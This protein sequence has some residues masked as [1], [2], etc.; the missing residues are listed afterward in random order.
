MEDDPQGEVVVSGEAFDVI[1]FAVA[2]VMLF[3]SSMVGCAVNRVLIT[4]LAML[5]HSL[6]DLLR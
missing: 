1:N 4:L 5:I 3:S 6:I 2:Y